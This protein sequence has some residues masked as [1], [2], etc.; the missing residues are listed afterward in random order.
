MARPVLK[1][2]SKGP[3]VVELQKLLNTKLTPSPALVPDGNFGPLT[4]AAVKAYQTT[5]WLVIDGIVG[6]CTWNALLGLELFNVEH[7]TSLIAQPTDTTC[8]KASTAMLLAKPIFMISNGPAALCADGSIDNSTSNMEIYAKHHNLKFNYPMS[9]LPTALAERMKQR[10]RLMFH[11]I[12]NV[13]EW[14]P[15]LPESGHLIVLVRM[16]GDG[17][18][19]GTSMTFLDPWAPNVGEVARMTYKTML[20]RMPGATASVLHKK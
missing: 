15:A 6:V 5:N 13:H 1:Q 19:E 8:W 14:N 16:R 17:T 18:A 7:P 9:W 20:Q 3:D 2:G 10:G 12:W 4:K 11:I